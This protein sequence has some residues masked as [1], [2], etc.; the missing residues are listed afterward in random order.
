MY[1]LLKKL[2]L[3]PQWHLA[4]SNFVGHMYV[5]PDQWIWADHITEHQSMH[6]YNPVFG[7]FLNK[8]NDNNFW[9]SPQT[10]ITVHKLILDSMD[11][12]QNKASRIAAVLPH[13]RALLGSDIDQTTVSSTMSNNGMITCQ[14]QR[15]HTALMAIFEF[16]ISLEYLESHYGRP[17]LGAWNGLLQKRWV[18]FCINTLQKFCSSL[19]KLH[20]QC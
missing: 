6:M 13:L 10:L 5:L 12:Y 7:K 1:Q 19:F 9:P 15:N 16:K 8:I 2:K 17:P 18:S 4:L 14:W 3:L 20:F 11:I